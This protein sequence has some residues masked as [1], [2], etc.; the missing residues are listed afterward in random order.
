MKSEIGLNAQAL[1]K[2]SLSEVRRRRAKTNTRMRP[3]AFSILAMSGIF[4]GTSALFVGIVCVIVHGAV[5]HDVVLNQVGTGLL[6]VAIPMILVGSIFL[7]KIE[8][9][10]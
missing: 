7:D 4:G 2:T 1:A 10:K 9:K 5:S 8:G 3:L 6:I